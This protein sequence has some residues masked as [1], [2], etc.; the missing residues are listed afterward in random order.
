MLTYG[1]RDGDTFLEYA[2]ISETGLVNQGWK[3]SWDSVSYRDGHLGEPPIALCEVQGY[4]YAAYRAMSYLAGRLGL[5][6]D[7]EH[8]NQTAQT[9]Q[10]N[11][12][13]ASGG[14]TNSP[15]IL[16]SMARSDPVMSSPPTRGIASGPA[17]CLRNGASPWSNVCS[18]VTCI[19]SGAYAR[20]P[21]VSSATTL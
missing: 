13:R 7:Q 4:A 11:F 10:L 19:P 1:D 16:R 14:K 20:S 9:L 2:K 12:L 21:S 18:R 5:H 17:S 15:F 8:W 6:E 3:D